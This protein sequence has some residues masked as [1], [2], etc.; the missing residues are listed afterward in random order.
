[1]K[2][3]FFN[4]IASVLFLICLF[5]L[6]LW[7][8]SYSRGEDIGINTTHHRYFIRTGGGEVGFEWSLYNTP[9][10]ESAFQWDLYPRRTKSP[11][12]LRRDT[13]LLRRGFSFSQSTMPRVGVSNALMIPMWLLVLSFLLPALIALRLGR[14]MRQRDRASMKKCVA[15][16]YDL[17]ATPNR[18]PECGEVPAASRSEDSLSKSTTD[19]PVHGI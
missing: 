16:G 7:V 13:F 5:A 3:H 4:A 11:Y 2:R 8:R 19:E 9:V 14:W 1:V 10:N 15:C 6:V 12:M 17:R 18:C